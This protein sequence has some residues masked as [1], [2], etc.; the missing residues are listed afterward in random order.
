M[1]EIAA[2]RAELQVFQQQILKSFDCEAFKPASMCNICAGSAGQV[3]AV[4]ERAGALPISCALSLVFACLFVS[5]A[6]F[7]QAMGMRRM[8][9]FALQKMLQTSNARAA[10]YRL[11]FTFARRSATCET[12]EQA[13][14]G[15]K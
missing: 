4:P 12:F 5:A 9:Y 10:R 15:A 2:L 3:E 13:V 14:V 6:F 11:H 8:S 1:A 7:I